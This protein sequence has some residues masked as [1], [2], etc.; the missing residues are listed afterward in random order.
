MKKYFSGYYRHPEDDFKYLWDNAFFVFDASIL[1][2]LFRYSEKTT[3]TLI[4]LFTGLKER[5][6]LPYQSAK[7]YH[8]N[9]LKVISQEESRIEHTLE[10]SRLLLLVIQENQNNPYVTG[11]VSRLMKNLAAELEKAGKSKTKPPPTHPFEHS[12]AAQLATLYEDKVGPPFSVNKLEELYLIGEER[13]YK[14][15][16]PCHF[17]IKSEDPDVRYGNIL[18][19]MQL[20]D[21][22]ESTAKPVIFVSGEEKKAWFKQDSNGKYII[23]H[24]LLI[25]EFKAEKDTPFW[26]YTTTQF[27][28]DLKQVF[29]IEVPKSIY[30]EIKNTSLHQINAS[31]NHAGEDMPTRLMG[32]AP[33]CPFHYHGTPQM[34]PDANTG[35]N[36][37]EKQDTGYIQEQIY[38]SLSNKIK[39]LMNYYTADKTLFKQVSELL[40]SYSVKPGDIPGI[41]ELF[42]IQFDHK[43]KSN[44]SGTDRV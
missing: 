6:W 24:P 25:N 18:I 31:Q 37:T 2:N 21:Q 28:E 20:L 34:V 29:H 3:Q 12:L 30:Q 8:E 14:N 41:S 26:I 19:W 17:T 23:P 22:V 5:L 36:G 32:R 43:L 40:K 13:S 9:M 7:E 33:V 10:A 15:I 38:Q 16:P 39:D 35:I 4:N 1:L 27:L 44:A 42:E 11:N